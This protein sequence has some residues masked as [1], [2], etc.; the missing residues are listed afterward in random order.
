MPERIDFW[1]IPHPWG[2]ILVYALLGLATLI[3]V[4]RFYQRARVWW[5]TGLPEKR[6]D[7]LPTRLGR[8]VKYAILQVRVLGQRYPGIMHAALAWSF[9]V[10]FLGTAFATIN[11]HFITFL[12]GSSYLVYKLTLDVFSVVFLVGAGMAAY[13]RFVLRP[14]RLTLQGKFT[15]SLVFLV[16]IVLNGLLIESLRLAIEKPAWALWSPAGW[17]IAQLWI[18]SGASQGALYNWH[19]GVYTL[20]F[21]TVSAFFVTLPTGTLVHL[22]TAPLNV[23]FSKIDR[24]A[25]RLAALPET[26]EGE[27]IYADRLAHLSW[28][29]ILDSEACTE[30]GR[31]QEVCPAYA[32]NK[33][34]SPKQLVVDIREKLH[35]EWATAKSKPTEPAPLVNG[36]IREADVWSCTTCGACDQ[37]C[38]VLVEHV[39]TLVDLRRSLVIEGRMDARLQDALAGLSR[40]GNSFG[41]SER[42]RAKWSQALPTKIKDA[43]KEPVEYLWFVGDYASYNPA[44]TEITRQAAQVFQSAGLDFGILYEAE[45]N[46]GND[47]R[48]AGEEGLFEYL[49]EKNSA[50]LAKCDF[51]AIFTTDPHTFNTLKNEYPGDV[52]AGRPVLH[53]TEVLERLI[54]RGQLRFE[55]ALDAVVTYHDPCYLGRYNGVYAAPRRVL[56]ALGC[57]LVEMPRHGAHA[58]CCGAGGGRIWM[59]EGE[60]QE[61]PS[62]NRIREAAALGSVSTLVVACP[63][64]VAMFR[65]ALKTTSLEGRLVVKDLVELV[66]EALEPVAVASPE[67]LTENGGKDG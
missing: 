20:H 9:F 34:L 54:A 42:N 15:W 17:A 41:Q 43:R 7:H 65:D 27:P 64:D 33:Q 46:A 39:D 21:V 57:R 28:K 29:Q 31:C 10:L 14:A 38:P 55:R 48:R 6:W 30:C 50:A 44:I 19:L 67:G 26:K 2:P 66:H 11:G 37:E 36:Q 49:V 1:G 40:Y 3:L 58:F 56:A 25:G 45:R 63:K 62:E 32:S 23:F 24:P 53:Y 60:M 59:E 22:L 35:E 13:R 5:Q 52:L 61:R 8:L 51:Q 16:F 18:A 47:A 4:V 12:Q